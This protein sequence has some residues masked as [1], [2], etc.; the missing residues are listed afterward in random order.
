MESTVEHEL[1]EIGVLFISTTLSQKFMVLGK[2]EICL[3]EQF[4]SFF[5]PEENSSCLAEPLGLRLSFLPFPVLLNPP[6]LL[7][8][9]TVF[10]LHSQLCYPLRNQR[11]ERYSLFLFALFRQFLFLHPEFFTC[12]GI[13]PTFW[14]WNMGTGRRRKKNK[15]KQKSPSGAKQRSYQ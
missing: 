4:L 9:T 10:Q 13:L 2:A 11:V 12:S 3:P 6:I 14:K 15:T 1:S 8:P 7:L 5:P